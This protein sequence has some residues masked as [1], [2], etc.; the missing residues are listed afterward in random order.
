MDASTLASLQ[1]AL[2]YTYGAFS[3]G[4]FISLIFYG[5]C[6]LQAYRYLRLY[7]TDNV[8]IKSLVSLLSGVLLETLHTILSMHTCYYYL[9]TNFFNPTVIQRG[10]WCVLFARIIYARFFARRVYLIGGWSRVVAI[11]A[12]VFLLGHIG[13]PFITLTICFSFHINQIQQF[14]DESKFISFTTLLCAAVADLLLTGAMIVALPRT[15]TENQNQPR[16][17]RSML[18]TISM[19]LINTGAIVHGIAA[20]VSVAWPYRLYWAATALVAQKMYAITL[21]A[22]LNSRTRQFSRGIEV[23]DTDTAFG[24]NIFSRANQLATVE[25]WNVPRAPELP[26]AITIKVAAEMDTD[27]Q[28]QCGS[29]MLGPYGDH[30]EP[31]SFVP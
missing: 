26:Q 27:G 3:I 23:Y 28:S 10:V 17:A 24:R 22:V 21:L 31:S 12:A 2:T 16:T 18:Q 7:P 30:K 14:T 20:I 15:R 6:I 8:F 1:S 25:Q 11:L 19:Y 29:K 13:T 4:T 5:M 9:V